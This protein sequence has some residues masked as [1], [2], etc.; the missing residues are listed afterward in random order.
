MKNINLL[1]KQ[2]FTEKYAIRLIAASIV[3]SLGI[4]S[5][6]LIYHQQIGQ[7]IVVKQEYSNQL[8][9][10]ISQ[11]MLE[12]Q[13]DT[14]TVKFQELTDEVEKL[15]LNRLNWMPFFHQVIETIPLDGRLNRAQLN[16]NVS[17]TDLIAIDLSV[18][19]SSLIALKEY[20][21]LLKENPLI[22]NV[23]LNGINN[24]K[25]SDP[26]EADRQKL[27]QEE[28]LRKTRMNMAPPLQ[29]ESRDPFIQSLNHYLAPELNLPALPD[30]SNEAD[31]GL[32]TDNSANNPFTSAD[33]N[34]AEQVLQQMNPAGTDAT[35]GDTTIDNPLDPADAAAVDAITGNTIQPQMDVT[36]YRCQLQLLVK[37]KTS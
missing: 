19:L 6:L 34:Q 20:V 17:T 27:I 25:M 24:E 14:R 36:F 26:G 5:S 15:K 18:D 11:L 16:N 3:G 12:K 33:F 4:V 13:P 1:V 30:Q 7:D 32:A 28:L 29:N 2:P 31:S 10:R 35:T 8:N 22:S 23:Q 37:L 9:A 21:T